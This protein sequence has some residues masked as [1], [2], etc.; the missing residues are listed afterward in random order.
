MK[1]IYVVD[2]HIITGNKWYLILNTR[3]ASLSN[4]LVL[5]SNDG[6]VR[7][8]QP[9]HRLPIYQ[10]DITSIGRHAMETRIQLAR[11]DLSKRLQDK[12]IPILI[13]SI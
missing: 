3:I 8:D 2:S 11:R 12:S 9:D 7:L 6:F 1:Y 5:I 13:N 4:T 10:E